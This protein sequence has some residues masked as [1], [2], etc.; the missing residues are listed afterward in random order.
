MA[1]WVMGIPDFLET[2]STISAVLYPVGCQKR[3]PS[4]SVRNEARDPFSGF[5][6]PLYFPVSSPP[7]SGLKHVIPIPASIAAGMASLSSS[8]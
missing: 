2:S 5:V 7:P 3:G 6:C 8:R 1:S 4:T